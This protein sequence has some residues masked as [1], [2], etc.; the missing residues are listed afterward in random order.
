MQL[1]YI[2]SSWS[3]TQFV[4]VVKVQAAIMTAAAIPINAIYC[5]QFFS[6]F[7]IINNAT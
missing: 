3:Q 7:V 4:F 5:C 6:L 2:Y 1:F